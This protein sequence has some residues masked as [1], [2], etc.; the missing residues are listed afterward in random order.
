MRQFFLLCG[1]IFTVFVAKA[2]ISLDNC[3]RLAKEHYPAIRQYDLIRQSEQ[4]TL[5]NISRGWL[6]QLSLSAQATLQ[7]EVPSLPEMFG[8]MLSLQGVDMIGISKDQYKISLDLYQP[9]W[10]GGRSKVESQIAKTE[11]LEQIYTTDVEFYELKKRISEL[12]FGI[13]LC[14]EKITQSSLTIELLESNLEKLRSYRRNGI[15]MQSDVDIIEAHLLSAKQQLTQLEATK[16][17]YRQMLDIFLGGKLGTQSLIRPD[18]SL[19][20]EGEILRPELSLLEAKTQR[21][22]LQEKALN[23]PNFP[24]FGLFANGFYG[25]PGFDFFKS[26]TSSDWSFNAMVGVKMS[27]NISSFNTKANS[28]AKIRTAKQQI[29]TQKD[30]FLF[31]TQMQIAK[32]RGDIERLE[33]MIENDRKIIALRHSV[34]Q[35]AESK[36]RNG[37]INTDDLLNRI[38]EEAS[39]RAA[40]SVREIELLKTIYELKHTINK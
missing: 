26:M 7:S 16:A 21:L 36:L 19:P 2:Q 34:R 6:P 40:L 30:I 31:N 25:Y 5:S 4:Y 9:I 38:T 28:K 24:Q 39:A 20:K 8:D 27:W 37:V 33:K 3:Q 10:D 12:F 22:S 11:A 15:A 35:A 13:L 23:V 29:E 14:E 32:Q 18:I 1:C 17:V